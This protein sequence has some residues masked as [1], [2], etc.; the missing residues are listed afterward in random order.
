MS[1]ASRCNSYRDTSVLG[2]D[3]K[4]MVTIAY[5]EDTDEP[6]Y[7]DTLVISRCYRKEEYKEAAEK[8]LREEI[9][10]PSIEEWGFRLEDV[11]HIY[12]NPTGSWLSKN[13]CSAADC[14]VDLAA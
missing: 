12:I 6:L 5:D 7:I 13:S 2:L 14:G 4:G 8:I 9:L 3:C 11:K 10:K 1:I